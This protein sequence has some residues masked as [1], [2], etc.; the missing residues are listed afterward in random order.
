MITITVCHTVVQ[1]RHQFCLCPLGRTLHS[2][3][4]NTLCMDAPTTWSL[5][6]LGAMNYISG[7]EQ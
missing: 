1:V 2:Y 6:K 3:Q 5:C 4:Y 7:R